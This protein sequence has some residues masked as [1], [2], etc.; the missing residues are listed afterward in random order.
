MAFDVDITLQRG[1]R[2]IAAQFATPGGLT[3]LFGPSA[4]G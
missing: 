2:T 4:A 3:A 1:A